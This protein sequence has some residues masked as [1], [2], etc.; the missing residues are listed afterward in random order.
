RRAAA[1][2]AD[3]RERSGPASPRASDA[4]R[5]TVLRYVTRGVLFI[6]GA[7]LP[8][9][10]IA[11]TSYGVLTITPNKAIGLVMLVFGALDLLVSGIRVPRNPKNYWVAALVVAMA[12]GCIYGSFLSGTGSSY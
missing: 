10:T 3:G 8:L 5:S 1:E 7:A 2:V 11:Y 6:L 9:E 12:I 4:T